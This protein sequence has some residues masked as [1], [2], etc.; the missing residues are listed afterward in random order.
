M[1]ARD[2]APA[3][4]H[5]LLFERRT[6]A[7]TA[8]TRQGW[9]ER[10]WKNGDAIGGYA[11]GRSAPLP[12]E[13]PLMETPSSPVSRWPAWRN[14][15]SPRPAVR[16]CCPRRSPQ[17]PLPRSAEGKAT[18]GASPEMASVAMPRPRYSWG[19]LYPIS[20]CPLTGAPLE[21]SRAKRLGR[22]S[23]NKQEWRKPQ[24]RLSLL[25]CQC[26]RPSRMN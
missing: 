2:A 15:A 11:D 19:C 3:A 10:R 18:P 24:R 17:T 4:S 7:V 22:H 26:L 16:V 20:M 1:I 6:P 5:A 8:A 13:Q 23:R 21:S 14:P 25:Q 12:G 9:G